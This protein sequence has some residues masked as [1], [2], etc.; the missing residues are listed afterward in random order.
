MIVPAALGG[1]G[2]Y[3]INPDS[4]TSDHGVECQGRCDMFKINYE[5][6]SVACRDGQ[7][8]Q[9]QVR[10]SITDT[11]KAGVGTKLI[12]ESAT[13]EP[14]LLDWMGLSQQMKSQGGCIII[15]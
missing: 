10:A 8:T 13:G 7:K 14:R 12:S 2:S 4:L 9:S 6:E 3:I 1:G 5:N 11:Q 15:D